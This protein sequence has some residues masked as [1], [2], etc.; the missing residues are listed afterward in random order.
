MDQI[1]MS[2]PS[3]YGTQP[4]YGQPNYFNFGGQGMGGMMLS[5]AGQALSGTLAGSTGLLPGQFAPVQSLYDMHRSAQEYRERTMAMQRASETDR[6][7]QMQMLRGVAQVS[8]TPW[9]A[10]TISAANTIT[11]DMATLSPFFAQMAPS[12]FD[13]MHGRGGSATV[14]ANSIFDAGRTRM[15]PRGGF[16]MSGDTAGAMSQQIY[17]DQF[18]RGRDLRGWN[19]V[20]AGAAG[21]MFNDLQQRGLM[22]SQIGA[23][24]RDEQIG[25]LSGAGFGTQSQIADLAKKDSG[26]FDTM[27][28]Q[29]DSKKISD[30]LKS[31]SGAVSA[32]RDIFGDL[33][34][35]DAP[36]VEI[37][38]GLNALTQGG[39][40]NMAPAEIENTVRRTHA[41]SR[42]T[43]MGIDAIAAIT[44][45]G[46]GIADQLGIDRGFAVD[47]SLNA[48]A[49]GGAYGQVGGGNFAAY[50]RKD[51]DNL[52]LADQEL[53]LRAAN[54]RL[55]NQM[56]AALRL[57]EETGLD[58]E[59]NEY[60]DAVRAGKD[61]FGKDKRSVIMSDAEWQT[62]MTNSGVGPAMAGTILR[63]RFT[64][65]EYGQ[66]YG[67]GN[68]ARRVQGKAD[69][70][71]MIRDTYGSGL[72]AALRD[73]G[74]DRGEANKLSAAATTKIGDAL[75]NM[76]P[77]DR[78]N[79]TARNEVM[80]GA[81]KEGLKA[82]GMT[83]EQIAKLEATGAL[84]NAAVAGWGNL[85]ERIR[86]D[87][88]FKYLE[89]GQ[90]MLDLND[91]KVL[92]QQQVQ[93]NQADIE[94]RKRKMTSGMGRSGLVKRVAESLLNPDENMAKALGKILGG[95]DPETMV[96]AYGMDKDPLLKGR[97]ALQNILAGDNEEW[98]GQ[99]KFAAGQ[100]KAINEGGKTAEDW[101]QKEARDHGYKDVDSMI[102][103]QKT[104]DKR[105]RYTEIQ[106]LAN[107]GIGLND[108]NVG[109]H[110]AKLEAGLG[111]LKGKI[112]ELD[113]QIAAEKDPVKKEALQQQKIQLMQAQD[114]IVHG[115]DQAK[116][117]DPK[118]LEG[119]GLSKDALGAVTTGMGAA[120]HRGLTDTLEDAGAQTGIVVSE[121]KMAAAA[122]D[123]EGINADRGLGMAGELIRETLGSEKDLKAL[124]SGGLE[125]ATAAES[126]FAKI[127]DLERT[128]GKS[129][130]TLVH[131]EGN[132]EA[133][134]LHK[135]LQGQ[136]QGL[137][138]RR[139]E[140]GAV[141]KDEEAKIKENIGDRSLSFNDRRKDFLGD[142]GEQYGID[143]EQAE[144]MTGQLAG[145]SPEEQDAVMRKVRKNTAGKKIEAGQE[146]SQAALSAAISS[147]MTDDQRQRRDAAGGGGD[148]MKLTGRVKLDM[149][150]GELVFSDTKAVRS[151]H[152]V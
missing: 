66:K 128:T 142:L 28:Q 100:L 49:F 3:M 27:L 71:P 136:L 24:S 73:S 43:G 38:N 14:L 104:E 102:A 124:G 113:K 149:A 33:G 32:M 16:G 68:T 125:A 129:L 40:A 112:N 123:L 64:N 135:E 115:G 144:G 111:A 119:L 72:F 78:T 4:G 35:P 17:Q 70:D 98:D 77:E 147:A 140:G 83:E 97:A 52:T 48:A 11:Q 99:K 34:R 132:A 57:A 75:L 131:G 13:A 15:D 91:P 118:S 76:R 85:E 133:V 95:I 36:M 82:A 67:V 105:K 10:S 93:M 107:A 55:G 101:L 39:L 47:A 50:G 117:Y 130:S 46:A 106:K 7:T 148:T 138:T 150:N 126:T 45:R 92:A 81:V 143:R 58:G 79:A 61:V 152:T 146:G 19:G 137:Q 116:N 69:L 1:S 94:A 42:Q 139:K 54:S 31:L 59:A 6:L 26:Q 51:R 134:A 84:Q 110:A 65:Q 63:D 103:G 5:M 8:G 62:M 80:A 120:K 88:K 37:M 29:F 60:A 25:M 41:L 23:F 96:N 87:D 12:T 74:M 44:S 30:R 53:R 56:S 90:K 122:K 141:T 9:T 22:P 86:T 20:G 127:K 18:A 108:M 151:G 121:E 114:A 109:K 2:G 21:Q 145:L 89:S